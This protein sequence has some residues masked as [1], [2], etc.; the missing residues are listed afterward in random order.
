MDKKRAIQIMTKSASLYRDN[1]EDQKIL[2]LYGIPAEVNKQLE[3]KEQL[4]RIDAYEATF[5]RGN[6]LHLTGVKINTQKI[7]SAIHFYEKK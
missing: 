4:A 3:A 6:F 7:K 5:H 1:L 2:F